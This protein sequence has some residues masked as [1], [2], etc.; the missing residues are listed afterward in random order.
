MAAAASVPQT[1]PRLASGPGRMAAHC[2]EHQSRSFCHL[3]RWSGCGLAPGGT[4]ADGEAVRSSM[5]MNYSQALVRSCEPTAL[6]MELN[7]V[8]PL[9]RL[10]IRLDRLRGGAEVLRRRRMISISCAVPRSV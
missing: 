4:G 6:Y 3:D 2:L 9:R 1:A 7:A 10:P 5:D 8:M